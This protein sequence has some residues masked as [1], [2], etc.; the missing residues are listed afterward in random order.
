MTEESLAKKLLAILER[1]VVPSNEVEELLQKRRLGF[2]KKEEFVTTEWKNFSP[3]LK[4]F[5]PIPYEVKKIDSKYDYLDRA[6]YFSYKFQGLIHKH[7]SEQEFLLKDSQSVPF[8][9]NTCCNTNNNVFRYFLKNAGL[10][11]LLVE[12]SEL[13]VEVYKYNLALMGT[14]VFFLEN[15]KKI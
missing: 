3:R 4:R 9:V 1:F 10:K 2:R 6:Y 7:L 15:T 11:D 12:I 5:T 8:L 13:S 14:K